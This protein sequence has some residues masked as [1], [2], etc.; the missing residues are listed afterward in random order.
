MLDWN[1]CQICCPLEI[2]LFYYYYYLGEELGGAKGVR[3]VSEGIM[4]S[5]LPKWLRLE[6][7][8]TEKRNPD[9]RKKKDQIC[10]RRGGGK[11]RFRNITRQIYPR[12]KKKIHILYSDK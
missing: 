6:G 8:E 10:S 7:L 2:K 4:K 11:K 3:S 12:N 1:S 9:R 5:L